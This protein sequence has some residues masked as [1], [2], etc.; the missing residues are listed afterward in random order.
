M[1]F[2]EI[3]ENEKP[4]EKLK[5]LGVENLTDS[6]LLAI[7]LRTGNKDESVLELSMR[8]LKEA[9]SLNKLS[10]MSI[11]NLSKIKGI[12]LSKASIIVAAFEL[13]RRSLKNIDKKVQLNNSEKIYNYFKN[14]FK[15][16]KQEKFYVILFDNKMN[17]IKTKELF[18]GTLNKVDIHPREIFKEA[19]KESAAFFAVMH[20][21]PS[22]D[23][24]PSEEDIKTT[25]TL[26]DLGN[27]LGIKLVDH[28]IISYEGYYS[29]YDYS[30]SLS[31][32]NTIIT[33]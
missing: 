22:G 9:S 32:Q 28:I 29:F 7:L 33:K 3:I 25:V 5:S 11:N 4:R 16:E 24:S 31:N 19:I 14:D 1:K 10:T 18:I 15:N 2:K 17:L 6:E 23:T 8:L 27:T 26:R 21:H 13:G 20:N 30:K 12:K